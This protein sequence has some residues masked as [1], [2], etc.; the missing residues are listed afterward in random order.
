[1]SRERIFQTAI[2]LADAEGMSALTMRRLGQALGVEAM[3]LYNHVANKDDLLN[4]MLEQVLRQIV[5][6][7]DGDGWKSAIRT[8]ALSAHTILLRHSWACQLMMEPGRDT[9]VRLRWMDAVLGCFRRGGFSAMLTHHAYHALDSHITG[10][11]LWLVNL[12][13]RGEELHDLAATFLPDVQLEELPYLAEHIE[14]HLR[15]IDHDGESEFEFGL[16]LILDGLERLRDA[17]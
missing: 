8:T 12:P 9:R 2:D 4:G 15:G 6:P 11:T 1:L 17:H 10:F 13:A 3:S 16:G 5:L 7:P 14:L